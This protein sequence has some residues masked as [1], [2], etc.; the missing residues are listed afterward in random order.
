MHPKFLKIALLLCL[1]TTLIYGQKKGVNK[2]EKKSGMLSFSINYSD[3]GFWK[4]V[5]DSSISYAVNR[6]GLFKSG[7]SSFGFGVSYWKGLGSHFD[8]SGNFAGTFSNFPAFM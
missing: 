1:S 7:S 2:P 8:F 4:A 5:N 3:Y 6:K